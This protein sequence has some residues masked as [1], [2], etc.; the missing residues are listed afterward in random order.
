MSDR[1]TLPHL[2]WGKHINALFVGGIFFFFKGWADLHPHNQAWPQVSF[3]II[4]HLAIA[5]LK[6]QERWSH[7]HCR[8][9]EKK[10]KK[11]KTCEQI[12]LPNCS[13]FSFHSIL[14]FSRLKLFQFVVFEY[15]SFFCWYNKIRVGSPPSPLFWGQF[16]SSSAILV[17]ENP[18]LFPQLWVAPRSAGLAADA[19]GVARRHSV[20]PGDLFTRTYLFP[21]SPP[22]WQIEPKMINGIISSRPQ[23]ASESSEG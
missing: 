3:P 21:Y 6:T 11:T 17:G 12:L 1:N 19:F 10:Q 5:Q 15:R 23:W 20:H 22:S 4:S 7:I 13:F 14:C 16:Y 2:L 9:Q 18:S 8:S